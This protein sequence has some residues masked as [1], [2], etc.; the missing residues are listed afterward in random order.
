[1]NLIHEVAFTLF[2]QYANEHILRETDNALCIH[3]L[4][5]CIDPH[6]YFDES[7]NGKELRVAAQEYASDILSEEEFN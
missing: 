4:P 6:D 2:R 7:M 3:D 1:M 5:D